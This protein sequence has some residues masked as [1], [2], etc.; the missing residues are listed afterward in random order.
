MIRKG[1]FEDLNSLEHLVTA[2]RL[3]M[4]SE[5]IFQWNHT[6][7]LAKDFENDINRNE[8]Y[9]KEFNDEI[10]GCIVLSNA[11][12]EFYKNISWTPNTDNALYVHRLAVLPKFQGQGIARQLMDFAENFG[13]TNDYQAIRLDTFSQNKR[14]QKFYLS[15]GY[16]Q[17]ESIYFPNQSEFPF[18]CYEL[19]L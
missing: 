14:N 2:C 17:L 4:E 10:I 16:T 18:Y 6:Y 3:K 5:N 9:V 7:P 1:C 12:D 19:I 11:M 15:R 13:K 8:L